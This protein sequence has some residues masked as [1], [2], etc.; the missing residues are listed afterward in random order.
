MSTAEST[1]GSIAAESLRNEAAALVEFAQRCDARALDDA[2]KLVL[3]CTGK[4]VVLGVG[5]S[6]IAAAK[7]AS[8]LSSTGTPAVALHAADALHGD[9]GLVCPGDAVLAI[10]N[11]GETEEVI[12]T[13][14]QV[15]ERG[16]PI[17]AVV[18]SRESTVA[19]QADVVLETG[20]REEAGL[21]K[22]APTTS[23]LATIAIGDALATALMQARGFT[24]DEFAANHPGGRLGRRLRVQVSD[25][26]HSGPRNPIVAPDESWL[27]VLRE[28]TRGGL[29]AVTVEAD[30]R[31]VGIVTDGDVRRTAQDADIQTITALRARDFMTPDP[32]T[33]GP[34]LLASDA[35]RVMEVRSSQISVLPVVDEDR[36]CLGLLRLHDVVQA[37]LR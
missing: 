32:I 21:L 33:V 10:S 4:V 11:G 25:L 35:L 18:A 29:G 24:A 13:I 2:S 7:I 36:R 8:T 19:R 23:V 17:A 37:G 5:K 1:L 14:A 6:A 28:I 16:V 3:G 34:D 27:D 15:R 9:V 20:I 31:I 12:A 30:G 26:M 22:V